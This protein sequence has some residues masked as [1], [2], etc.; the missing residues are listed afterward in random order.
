M[1]QSSPVAVMMAVSVCGGPPMGQSSAISGA[2]G[3]VMS[4]AWSPD[5]TRLAS[6]GGRRGSGELISGI[7]E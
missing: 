4:V 3:M 2:R 1:G 6:G 7:H 5:G